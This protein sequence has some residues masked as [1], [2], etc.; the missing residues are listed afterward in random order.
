LLYLLGLRLADSTRYRR[1]AM[2]PTAP[3]INGRSCTAVSCSTPGRYFTHQLSHL[4]VDF[5][6]IRDPF[7][8]RSPQR[9]LR[10]QPAGDI[11]AAGVR[12]PEPVGVRGLRQALLGIH[13]L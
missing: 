8:Q 7:M 5:R 4:W 13:G 6:G 2:P 3:P 9:L 11:R 10:E 1:R 12:R